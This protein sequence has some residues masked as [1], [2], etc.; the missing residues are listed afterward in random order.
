MTCSPVAPKPSLERYKW[1]VVFLLWWIC[2]FNY[3]DRQA[4]SSVLPLLARE[5]DLGAVEIGLVGSA[6]AW[7]YAGFA[8]VAGL[9]ADWLSRK[10]LI[11]A[12]C[13]LW[14]FFTLATAWCGNVTWLVT[15]R[16]LTGLAETFYFPAAMALLSDYHTG[17]TRSRAMSLHQSAVYVGTILGSWFAALLAERHG[18]RFPFFWFGP[19]GILLAVA[20]MRWLREPQRGTADAVR[21]GQALP[22]RETLRLIVRSPAALLLMGGF[23]C[24]NCIATIFLIWTPK[25]LVDKFH[26]GIGAAGLTGTLYIH[27]AS[28][29]SVPAAG[30]LGDQ[31]TQRLRGGRMLVQLVGLVAGAVFIF[32]VGQ[33]RNTVTLLTAMVGF[34]LCKGFYDSGIFASLYDTIEPRARGTAAGIMNTV[35]WGGGAIGPLLFGFATQFGTNATTVENMSQALA[36]GGAL[37]VAGALLVGL[38][39]YFHRRKHLGEAQGLAGAPNAL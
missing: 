31:V 17:E 15:V 33:A 30:W 6:F 27:L 5:F 39:L 23:L 25:F 28:A 13:I 26:Y 29:L 7:V 24:A 34:G 18:W 19:A 22:V 12:A 1:W 16:A 14:S 3:A 36:A 9:A 38:A 32:Y 4:I 2:F 11:I 35:G 20:A 21:G 37:Y 8:P 10:R